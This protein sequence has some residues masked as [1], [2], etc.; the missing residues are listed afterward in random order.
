M[1]DLP[2]VRRSFLFA[3]LTAVLLVLSG[4]GFSGAGSTSAAAD[5]DTPAGDETANET[6]TT[7]VLGLWDSPN[8]TPSDSSNTVSW[9]FE[10]VDDDDKFEHITDVG[11]TTGSYEQADLVVTL[12][13]APP[14]PFYDNVT[15]EISSDGTALTVTDTLANESCV[16]SRAS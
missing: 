16:F 2:R 4:C 15:I 6:P 11:P 13:I 9:E 7:S 3:F 5:S 14:G 12:T 1:S 8:C 10:N